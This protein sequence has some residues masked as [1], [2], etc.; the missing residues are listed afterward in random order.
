MRYRQL[1][2][3]ELRV[4]EICLGTM[5][6]GIQNSEAE[7]HAQ[8]DLA[9]DRGVNFI[10]TAEMYPVPASA[11]SY[12]RTEEVVGTWLQRKRRDS[13]ILATKVAGP[14]R[15][16]QWIRGGPL[17]LDRANIR[18]ALDGSLKRLRTDYV[19]LYQLHWPDRNTPM[20]G[21]YQFD[22]AQEHPTV[23]VAEQLEA[24][25]ELVRE[26][27]IRHI[28]LSNE[29]PWGVTEFLTQAD[30][31]G[32]AR[33]VS[34]QNAY[35]LINRSFETSLAE[36]C[37]RERISLLAYSPLAFGLLTGKYVDDPA[38]RGRVTIFDGFA[39]RYGKPNVRPAVESYVALARRHGIAPAV[40]ALAFV[41]GRW[42]IGSTIVGA[43]SLAQLEQNLSAWEIDLSPELID[44]IEQ[45]H[46]RYTNPAP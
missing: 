4:S 20:F 3:S 9:L 41:V 46:L 32:L 34:V 8:L 13:V 21:R 5:T 37:Y 7:G 25:T 17:A 42:F 35:S 44:E 33:V 31:Q 12:G 27:K 14:S 11:A 19:D 1:G 28:G 36:L 23:P 39:Q 10:D 26:G 29:H 22:P 30:K 40:M 45:I 18:A 16:L 38:T 6:F 24:L 15:N 43:T 2:G